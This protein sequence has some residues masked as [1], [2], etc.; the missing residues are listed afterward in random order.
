MTSTPLI[1]LR[2]WL[3]PD[4]LGNGWMPLAYLGYLVFLFMP[5]FMR[6]LP[7]PM[8]WSTP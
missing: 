2:R 1:R 5:M 8:W 3:S 7:A 4:E 6:L